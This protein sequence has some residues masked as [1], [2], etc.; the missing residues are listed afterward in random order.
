M[1][2]IVIG[3][4]HRTAPLELLERM[5]VPDTQVP[6]ALHDLCSREHISEAMVLSTCNRAE[7]SLRKVDLAVELQILSFYQQRKT[8]SD[9]VAQVAAD[10]AA[11]RAT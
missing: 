3:L 6:K 1:S 5:N 9:R 10:A 2:L 4:N 7:V 8:A 11:P